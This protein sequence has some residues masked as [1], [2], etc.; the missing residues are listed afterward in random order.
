[1]WSL[2]PFYVGLST[3]SLN[4]TNTEPTSPQGKIEMLSSP[5]LKHNIPIVEQQVLWEQMVSVKKNISF[6]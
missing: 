5:A 3:N 2:Q 6:N 1:M 4:Y